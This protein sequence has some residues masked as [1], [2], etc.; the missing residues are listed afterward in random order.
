MTKKSNTSRVFGQ[1]VETAGGMVILF[2]PYLHGNGLFCAL[3]S[4]FRPLARM[5]LLNTPYNT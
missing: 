4:S 3:L 1:N 2:H 5:E